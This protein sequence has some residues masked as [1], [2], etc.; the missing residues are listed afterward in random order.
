MTKPYHIETLAIH[1][2]QQPDPSTGA[3][4]TPIYQT[5]TYVQSA[6]GVHKGYEYSRT[7]NPTR[8]ALE[9]CLAALEGGTHGLAFSSGMAAIDTVL[10]LVASGEHVLAGN[11]VY[12]GTF[13]LLDK[14]LKDYGIAHSFVEMTDLRAVQAGLRPDTRMV[15]LETPTNPRLKV[16]DIEAIAALAHANGPRTLVMVDNTFAT[17]YLQRPLALG[18]DIVAHSTTKYLGG[19]SDVV[20]GAALMNDEA[21]FERLKFLQNAVGAVPGPMDC[22]LVLRGL[23]T[24]ALRM[25]R[26]AENALA[27]AQFLSDHP[28]VK[29]VIYPGLSDHPQHAL[30]ARQMRNGGGMLSFVMHGGVAAARRVVARTHLFALAESLGGV[31]S[32]IEIPAAMT[33]ASTA[34]S[35]LEVAPGLIRVSVG[36]EHKDDLIADLQQ[37]LM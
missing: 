37:A 18:A 8:T 10:R 24:L 15:L 6:V 13:R 25:D 32:L 22:W 5:S 21:V 2:G 16:F 34:G 3:V 11:D 23:K 1:A 9:D 27:V 7:G 12:G 29:E 4:M 30:A 17:P 33:H 35:P 14:V 26:H 36:L 20:G 28:E 19:H 31:E